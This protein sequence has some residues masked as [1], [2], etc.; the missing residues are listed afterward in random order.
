MRVAPPP[1]HRGE[2]SVASPKSSQHQDHIRPLAGVAQ[3]CVHTL[4]PSHN[5]GSDTFTRRNFSILNNHHLS[6][7][8][9]VQIITF[10]QDKKTLHHLEVKAVPG[11]AHG[12]APGDIFT[13]VA[14]SRTKTTAKVSSPAR[15]ERAKWC[16]SQVRASAVQWQ[17]VR[18]ENMTESVPVVPILVCLYR[19]GLW[20]GTNKSDRR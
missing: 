3:E 19:A 4:Y 13:L 17:V 20:A 10:L 11:P 9:I 1:A 5:M 15:R 16:W 18:E 7:D 8:F 14:G 2:A 12:S 6:K